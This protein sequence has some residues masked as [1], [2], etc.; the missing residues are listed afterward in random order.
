MCAFYRDDRQQL[1]VDGLSLAE[2]TATHG[3]PLYVY[4][5]DRHHRGLYPVS[6]RSGTGIRQGAF[7]HEGK[8]G[9]W[10]FGAIGR[11][12]GGMDI[13]SSGE[14][15]RAQAA[16][17]DPAD[18]VFSGVGKTDDDIRQALACGIGQIN[19]DRFPKSPRLV[20]LPPQW[21]LWHPWRL[22]VN[23][24][25]N[26]G[27]HAKISTGQ[28]DTKFGISTDQREA[29]DLYRVL[30]DDPHIRP[31]GLAVHIGSQIHGTLT[32]FEARLFGAAVASAPPC[33]TK[34][35]KCRCQILILAAAS[36]SI[37]TWMARQLTSPLMAS[38]SRT[39]VQ[40]DQRLSPSDLS[41]AARSLPITVFW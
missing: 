8:F 6:S 41:P 29:S 25:V 23:V 3:S 15:A 5:G 28:R 17:I 36:G 34:G 38:L 4:S 13:V 27:T 40:A 33:V 32:P 14:L 22:R 2:I 30:C 37:M 20:R 9:A 16:G 7:R 18:V 11:L 35:W 10:G 24:D 39:P 21:A 26:P 12:G 31:A 19:A 1:C